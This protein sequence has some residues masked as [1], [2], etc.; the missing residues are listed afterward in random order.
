MVRLI[1]SY[2]SN[3]VNKISDQFGFDS[4]HIGFRLSSSHYSFGSVQF[5][6]SLIS[7]F[8]SKI[9][10]TLS[11]VDSGLGFGRLVWVNRIGSL[12]SGLN[13]DILLFC[14]KVIVYI[15]QILVTISSCSLGVILGMIIT[16]LVHL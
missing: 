10:S 14:Y 9:G 15:W 8:G 3:Q 2:G 16:C 6:V 12:S 7:D 1:S 5:W 4:D 13:S 11:H